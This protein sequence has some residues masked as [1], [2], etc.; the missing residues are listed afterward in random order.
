[1]YLFLKRH[2]KINMLF[3][4]R[5]FLTFLSIFCVFDK[6]TNRFSIKLFI[7][8]DTNASFVSNTPIPIRYEQCGKHTF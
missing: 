8:I 1:M 5:I 6:K 3:T 2:P 7:K 4:N